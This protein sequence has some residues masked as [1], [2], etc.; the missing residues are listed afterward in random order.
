MAGPQR[1]GLDE[2]VR[3]GLEFRGDPRAV[4]ADSNARYFGAVL[5]EDTLLPG[6]DAQLATT[7]FE[8]WLPANPPPPAR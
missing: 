6:D 2:L 5:A 7:R 3:I 8:E 1:F 4:V